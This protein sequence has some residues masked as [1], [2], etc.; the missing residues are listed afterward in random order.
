MGYIIN[1]VEITDEVIEEEFEAIKEHYTNLG[2]AVCCDRDEEFRKTSHENV[3]NRTLLMQ[4]SVEKYGEIEAK[5]VEARFEQLKSDHGGE[6]QFYANTG[7][8]QSDESK[9]RDKIESTLAV[10]RVLETVVGDEAPATTEEVRAHYE[11]NI[12]RFMTDEEVHV[13]QIFKEPAS[14]DAAR[15]CYAELREVR[16]K[17]LDGEDFMETAIKYGD[18]D[19]EEID[20]GFLKQGE[21]MP[22]VEAIV[23]S[24]RNGEISPIVA[25]HFGFHV[26]KKLESKA[27]E[28]I[29][30][31]TIQEGLTNEFEAHRREARMASFIAELR[32][33]ATIEETEPVYS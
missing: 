11:K 27:P 14:H 28:P 24:M 7:F 4:A 10:D 29:A 9:I 21:T 6:E 25:T 23:F 20:F 2:E 13:L 33:K 8:S 32:E 26:F 30:F 15:E 3:I 22:E 18:K 12:D 31:E 19:E 1:G 5:E 16:E 17:L